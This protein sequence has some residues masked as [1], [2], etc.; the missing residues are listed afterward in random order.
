LRNSQEK[1][2]LTV[3]SHEGSKTITKFRNIRAISRSRVYPVNVD[4]RVAPSQ[5]VSA[6][7]KNMS[8]SNDNGKAINAL[9]IKDAEYSISLL[10][11]CIAESLQEE[12][13]TTSIGLLN[14]VMTDLNELILQSHRG[15]QIDDA[16]ASVEVEN[17]LR[18]V[19]VSV[20]ESS[21][22]AVSALLDTGLVTSM[23]DN[24]VGA[25]A[26]GVHS[27]LNAC[28]KDL[29]A[30]NEFIMSRVSKSTTI[31]ALKANQVYEVV[32]LLILNVQ[33]KL[34]ICA[35]FIWGL[36]DKADAAAQ[37]H[38]IHHSTVYDGSE[39]FGTHHSTSNIQHFQ[40]LSL[41]PSNHT[42]SNKVF[43]HNSENES[44]H[45]LEKS[46]SN[47]SLV[48]PPYDSPPPPAAST[49]A[50]N[51]TTVPNTVVSGSTP[52]TSLSIELE[53]LRR[54]KRE[55]EERQQRERSRQEEEALKDLKFTR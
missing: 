37:N 9:D 18:D 24:T 52:R 12:F 41:N 35:E 47:Q 43:D 46:I 23:A 38:A 4:I 53:E 20:V 27:L 51:L 34:N 8:R 50:N 55:A 19:M 2:I 5:E 7:V 3:A 1:K 15:T 30:L 25:I 40:S 14:S 39:V 48:L 16:A 33:Q 28:T 45:S 42:Q 54:F 44:V 36:K 6:I 49:I 32:T 22:S 11:E 29:D 31:R 21:Q 10:S 17:T 26:N 13:S